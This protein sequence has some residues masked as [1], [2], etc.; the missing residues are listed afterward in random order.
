VFLALTVIGLVGLLMLALPAL[1][2]HASLGQGHGA[3]AHPT[4]VHG[5]PH[6]GAGV[7]KSTLVVPAHGWGRWI[8]APRA[9]FSLCALYGAFGNALVHA[10]HLTVP[11]AAAVALL[12]ALLVERLLVRPV[13]NLL[14]R[15]QGAPSSPLEQLVMSEARAVVPFRNGRGMVAIVRDGRQVQLPA[16]LR[17]QDAGAPVAFGQRLRIEDVEARQERV[18]VSIIAPDEATKP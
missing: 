14:F 13:W 8:P 7:D 15:Y 3:A 4:G 17:E 18:T 2:G 6:V 10:G 11:V 12:P 9:I 1:A 5:H 16:R